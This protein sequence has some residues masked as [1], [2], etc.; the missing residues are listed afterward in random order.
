MP[1]PRNHVLDFTCEQLMIH[2]LGKRVKGDLAS[3]FARCRNG[4]G[5]LEWWVSALTTTQ[6]LST[7]VRSLAW[8]HSEAEN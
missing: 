8:R 3:A 1:L 4:V 7:S 2:N 5:M 6:P